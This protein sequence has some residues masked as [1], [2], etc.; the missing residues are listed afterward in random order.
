MCLE[1]NFRSRAQTAKKDIICYKYVRKIKISSN[2]LANYNGAEFTGVINGITCSGV[3]VK[4][5]G[6]TFFCTDEPG[7]EGLE[8]SERLG[9]AYSWVHDD[10]VTKIVINGNDISCYEIILKTPF[11]GTTIE[12]GNT[13][14][15]KLERNGNS[16]NRGLHSFKL[17]ED[18]VKNKENSFVSAGASIIVECVIPKGSKY[19]VG[20]FNDAVSYASDKLVYVKII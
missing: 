15:S 4:D 20:E 19:Y 6:N 9:Y 5:S 16:V 13:Y 1:L 12:I 17:Y 3:I 10:A 11:Q 14:V 7:L 8:T 2:D 18:C